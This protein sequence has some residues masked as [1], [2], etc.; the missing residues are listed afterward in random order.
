MTNKGKAVTLTDADGY[1]DVEIDGAARRLDL[2][3]ASDL[4]ADAVRGLPKD[5]GPDYLRAYYA[6]LRPAVA[7]LLGRADVSGYVAAEVA[8]A[9]FARAEGVRGKA[10]SPASAT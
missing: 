9:V 2:W 6:A 8:K 3:E 10:G 7:A 1:L 5:G 4:L